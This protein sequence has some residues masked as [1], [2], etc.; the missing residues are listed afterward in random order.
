MLG[1]TLFSRHTLA[2]RAF[3]TMRVLNS[4]SFILLTLKYHCVSH[5]GT[6]PVFIKQLKVKLWALNLNFY[7][8][9]YIDDR[10]F[11]K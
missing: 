11:L 5:I 8:Q 4:T 1:V 3:C 6:G 9:T 7:S 2:A 10:T